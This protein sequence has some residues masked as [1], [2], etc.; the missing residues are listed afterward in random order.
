LRPRQARAQPGRRP[1]YLLVPTRRGTAGAAAAG[2]ALLDAY[3]EL[4]R[5]LPRPLAEVAT[6][7]DEL[8]AAL[9]WVVDETPVGG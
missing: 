9:Q 7:L 1:L 2:E 3:L 8:N 4:E 6:E 5:R